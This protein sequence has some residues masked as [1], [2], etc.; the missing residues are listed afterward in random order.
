MKF[1]DSVTIHAIAGHGGQGM[2]AYRREKFVPRGGPSGG[3]GGHGG[4]V[5]FVADRNVGTLIDLRYRSEI[6][7]QDGRRGEPKMKNGANAEDALVRVPVGTVV[8]DASTREIIGDLVSDGDVCV[9]AQGGRGG[10]GNAFFKTS[11]NQT[12]SYAQPG[13]SGAELTVTLEL[14][15]LADIGIIGFPSVGKSTLISVISNARPKIADYHFTT[16]TPNLGVVRWRDEDSFVV[17]DIPGLI[18]GA[19]EG[20]GLGYQFLRHVERCR[21][22]CHV[23][24]VTP[25]GEDFDDGRDPIED[26]EALQRE[27]ALFSEALAARPQLVALGKMD[28]PFVQEREPELRAHFEA[29][30]FR[31]VSFSS[32]TRQGLQPLLD[33]MGQLWRET[34]APEVGHFTAVEADA[35][36][37]RPSREVGDNIEAPE[38]KEF[39]TEVLHGRPFYEH[40]LEDGVQVVYVGD[41]E[42]E[43]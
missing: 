24:E 3:N 41:G 7:A 28:L 40:L 4:S 31:F 36:R 18:E 21:A 13:E 12:P 37:I 5:T 16:L 33:A 25:G 1:V 11:V 9:A 14:K 43:G 30:G 20:R 29:L 34:P 19:H 22:L 32:V 10:K 23:I 39:E 8:R 38:E 15:L 27:L 2:V 35:S 42:G 6:R 17:A 26:F